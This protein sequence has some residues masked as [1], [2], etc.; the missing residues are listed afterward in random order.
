MPPCG[1]NLR[2]ELVKS[3]LKFFENNKCQDS[4]N[5][6]IFLQSYYW[7]IFTGIII[8]FVKNTS[9]KSRIDAMFLQAVHMF[10]NIQFLFIGYFYNFFILS[11][12]S[13]CLC[14]FNFNIVA[15][16]FSVL[17]SRLFVPLSI[18]QSLHSLYSSYRIAVYTTIRITFT[19]IYQSLNISGVAKCLSAVPRGN[20]LQQ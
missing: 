12:T 18:A 15:F 17:F 8:A 9:R 19:F 1:T 11:R 7:R 3:S 10:C 13:D 5:N 6:K 14:L 20:W 4:S 2:C 16:I